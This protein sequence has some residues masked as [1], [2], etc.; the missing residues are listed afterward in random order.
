[1]KNGKNNILIFLFFPIFLGCSNHMDKNINDLSTHLG[2]LDLCN[3]YSGIPKN[4]D[5]DK[6]SGMVLIPSGEIKVGSSNGY[7]DEKPFFEKNI[8]V[9][10]FFIDQTEVTVGQFKK[11]VDETKYI[12]EAE[13]QK[14]AAVF[15]SENLNDQSNYRHL[16]WWSFKEGYSWKNIDGRF[17][18]LNEPVRYITYNDAIAYANWLGHDLPTEEEI[19]YVAKGFQSNEDQGPLLNG[20]I[21]ANYWQGEFPYQNKKIDGFEGVAPVGCFVANPFKVYDIIGNVWELTKTPYTGPHSDNH[22]GNPKEVIKQRGIVSQITIKGGSF[23][24]A[25]NYCARYRASARHPHEIN[26]ATS[27]VGFRTVKRILKD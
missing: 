10:S 23:L 24:C 6:K 9:N 5:K 15:N 26:L 14:G 3:S 2:D 20:K 1:M 18:S 22:M 16:N 12:T 17:P 19:E 27:H 13:I 4:W 7:F 21:N 8:K 25:Q 11:F